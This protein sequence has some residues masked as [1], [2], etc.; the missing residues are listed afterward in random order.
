MPP[1]TPELRNS[2]TWMG[3]ALATPTLTPQQLCNVQLPEDYARPWMLTVYAQTV[4][5]G[6]ITPTN[7]VGP[8]QVAVPVYAQTSYPSALQ[9]RIGA[10]LVTM[11]YPARGAV[12]GVSPCAQ[13]NVSLIA[14]WAGL[15]P[16]VG[17]AVPGYSARLTE[18][19]GSGVC[20]PTLAVPRY[21]YSL[22]NLTVGD[23]VFG[24]VPVRAQSATLYPGDASGAGT[25][26][27]T[28]SWYDDAGQL[29]A[30]HSIKPGPGAAGDG[31]GHELT[32]WAIPPRASQWS[33]R[34]VGVEDMIPALVFHL[35]L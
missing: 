25:E 31:V 11:D 15:V 14:S 2:Q 16:P 24:L 3:R 29:V 13:C 12:Y 8:S 33:L 9:V 7:P 28:M 32:P 27:L 20:Q 26:L 22:G 21:T 18:A 6:L 17:N 19:E 34:L 30:Q 23:T 35:S 1:L 10:E 4:G 5:G